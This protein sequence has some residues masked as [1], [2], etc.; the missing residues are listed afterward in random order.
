MRRSPNVGDEE[1]VAGPPFVRYTDMSAGMVTMEAGS[2]LVWFA[3]MR[4]R[5][6]HGPASATTSA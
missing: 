6:M 5:P 4:N 2:L 3:G 1:A